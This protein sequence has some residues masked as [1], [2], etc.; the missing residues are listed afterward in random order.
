MF[1]YHTRSV[2]LRNANYPSELHIIWFGCRPVPENRHLTVYDT[3]MVLECG[4]NLAIVFAFEAVVDRV[5]LIKQEQPG[6]E[7][8]VR[9]AE[10][11][12]S[13]PSRHP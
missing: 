2:V 10:F 6:P 4:Q 3:K 11:S 7:L 9:D 1:A 8:D 12:Q 13:R 5:L